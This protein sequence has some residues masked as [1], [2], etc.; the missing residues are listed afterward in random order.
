[1]TKFPP[2]TLVFSVL[3]L[4]GLVGCSSSGDEA[5]NEDTSVQ[6]NA[7]GSSDLVTQ[8]A[9]GASA[10][11]FGSADT[12][13]LTIVTAPGNPKQVASFADLNKAGLNKVTAVNFVESSVAV[14][15]SPIAVLKYTP[16]PDLAKKFVDLVTGEHG[17]KVLSEAGFDKP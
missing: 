12:N 10:D 17:Q 8:L 5:Q 9:Q 15:T 2:L 16:K 13:T 4:A 6:V 11:V 3:L 7:A 14:N 1:V